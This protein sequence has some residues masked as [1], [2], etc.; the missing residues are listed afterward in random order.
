MIIQLLKKEQSIA[1]ILNKEKSKNLKTNPA[2]FMKLHNDER[3]IKIIIPRNTICIFY[4]EKLRSYLLKKRSP[5][6]DGRSAAN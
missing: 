5:Y 6:F 1:I 2:C 4:N 3:E